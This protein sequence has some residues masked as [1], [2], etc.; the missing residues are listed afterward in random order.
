MPAPTTVA[1][2]VELVRKSGLLPDAKLDE[3]IERHQIHGTLPPIIDPFAA[4]LV[5]ESLLTFFQAKQ[6]KLGRYKR[7]TIGSTAKPGPSRHSTTRTSSE[8]TTSTCTKNCTSS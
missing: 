6:L 1:E 3:L 8:P 4:I 2:F 5:R 7:F